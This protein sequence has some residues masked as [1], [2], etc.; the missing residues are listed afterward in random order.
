MTENPSADNAIDA[1]RDAVVAS[2][3]S[4]REATWLY[5]V[6]KISYG[7]F[8]LS[9][10]LI[11][12]ALG[13]AILWFFALNVILTRQTVDISRFEPN[14]KMW[15]SEAFNGSG[16]D[17]GA[18][19][20]KWRPGTKNIVFEAENIT[21]TDKSGGEIET[22][23]R[24]RTEIPLAEAAKGSLIPQQVIIEGGAV[25]WLRTNDGDVIAGLGTPDTVGRLGP[26]WRGNR[27]SG[28]TSR[29]DVS[30]IQTVSVT[31]AT[32][33]VVDDSDGLE[34][35][36]ENTDIDFINTAQSITVDMVSNLRKGAENIPL[37]FNM[38]ASPNVKS[39][40]IDVSAR[41]L[42]PSI[43][44]PKRG[45]FAGLKTLNTSIN[46]NASVSVDEVNGLET[47]E[48]DL[49]AGDGR[50][51]IGQNMAVFD[52]GKF[53]ASLT[54]ESQIMEIATIALNSPKLSFS[55]EGTLS[56]LGALTD[57]NINSSPLF[58]LKLRDLTFDQTPRFT[59]PIR[60]SELTTSGRMDMDSRRLDLENLT[61]N[62]G[63]YALSIRGSAQQD[64]EGNW[65][66]INLKGQSRGTLGPKDLLSIWP[67][68]FA[69][70]ARRWIDRS[71][72]QASLQN[73]VFEANLPQELL[74][75]SRLPI[76][77]DLELTFDV[78]G[79]DVR[80]ISTMTPFI[81]TSGKGVVR[82]NSAMFEAIGGTIGGV[83]VQTALADIPRLQP[84]GGDL[85]VTVKGS[86]DA[87]ELMALIDEKPF[88]F[89]SKYGVN[90]TEFGGTG[91]V[92]LTVTRPLLVYFD[93]AR[94]KY[95]VNGTFQNASA[96]FALGPHKLKNGFVTMTVDSNGMAVK[97]PVNIGPWKAD[98]NWQET[99]DYGATPTRVRVEGQMDRDTLD[100]FGV[101][102]R[103]YFDGE[104]GV[105]VD[106]IGTGLDFSSAA[107]TAD[108]TQT[109]M[110]MREYWQKEKGAAG[111]LSGTLKRGL[112]G[113]VSFE[114]M[115]LSA[116][117]FDVRGQVDLA[118]NL[119]LLNLNI[120]QANIT[121]FINA[122]IQAKPDELGEKLSVFIT[123]Q[124]LD[125]SSFVTAGLSNSSAG[126]DVPVLLTAGLEKLALNEA[127]IVE[128]ANVL[129]AHNGIGTTSA[130]LSGKTAEGN[131]NIDLQTNA[132]NAVRNAIVDI[133]DASEAAFAF[134]GLDNISGGRLQINAQMPPIGQIGPI[135]GVAEVE[136]FKL[137]EA[138]ILA[139]ML[140]IAS[141]QGIFDT[142]GGAGLNFNEFVVPFSFGEGQLSVRN[143]RVS[144]PALGMTGSG[145]IRL[146]DRVLD[147]DGVLVPAYTANSLLGD[148]PIIGDIFVG[149][150][151]EG[152]F[153]LSYTVKGGFDKTQIAV[154]PLSALTP[155]FLRGIF[156][157]KRDKLPDDV[158]TEIESVTPKGE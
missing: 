8:S 12:I 33:Y 134:L 44:S 7:I 3:A 124:Y 13:L 143:A 100:G 98:L 126:L 84:V 52:G 59:A 150:K 158:M 141:L 63:A 145:E 37:T 66:E 83:Q 15:F 135:N 136:D 73:L 68:E 51:K 43:I 82:G 55:G 97:G 25:T 80:Y 132:E 18:M 60:L 72:L 114:N 76:N 94:I 96:P 142:L 157:T 131:F 109:S 130:R 128:G 120:T 111:E 40:S 106:A 17:I 26:V 93:R 30:G 89:A 9:G 67:V 99:F 140:S 6:K 79:G 21:I 115:N 71:I 81:N 110:Q 47:A 31:N 2:D 57:G 41:G 155:G 42:N 65:A 154:N 70:G 125:A 11:A 102:L 108:L 144:G 149:K 50:V 29:P 53:K 62:F 88:E 22:I 38:T 137:I 90:P 64:A 75:G 112:D 122:A 28:E 36:F 69:D 133:P 39:Y 123:G 91:E 117:G 105:K 24:L 113:S 77:D 32:A 156:R 92:E 127:Y 10:E 147:L 121:G 16:A 61:A 19:Q 146:K 58:D 35:T 54:A 74:N 49:K 95:A 101:G 56:E 34:L 1:E 139:Q 151:G 4:L 153:A 107:L 104:I 152:I 78:T 45:R 119:K 46:L 85:K 103:E 129:L 148:I 14:A 87:S 48:V 20:L 23:P 118:Q 27:D 5:W 138:P 86:G 116:P